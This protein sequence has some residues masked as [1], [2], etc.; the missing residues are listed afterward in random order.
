MS[1]KQKP[2]WVG[3]TVVIILLIIILILILYNGY[4]YYGGVNG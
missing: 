1:K 2:N 3:F 4:L